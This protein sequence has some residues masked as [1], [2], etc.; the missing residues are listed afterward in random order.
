M[1]DGD[2]SDRRDPSVSVEQL[3]AYLQSKQWFED[4]RIRGVA[5]IWHRHQ[6]ND[7]EVVLPF[8][9]AKDFRQRVRDALMAI[10]SIEEREVFDVI[11]DVKRLF[12][13]VITVRVIHADTAD[14]TIPINDGV[15]L[16]SKAK[17]LLSA[18]AQ[19]I[20]AKRK[21]FSGS[22][23]KDTRDYLDTLLLGQTEI[24]SYVVNV[25]APNPTRS[26]ADQDAVS[27]TTADAVPL[28]QAIT[29]NLVTGLDALAKASTTY[30]QHGDLKA[31]DDAVLS[32]ASANLCDALL[33]FSG[34]KHN[35]AFEITVSA[36]AGPMFASE[37]RTFL[38]DGKRV[39]ALEKAS[40]YF[41]DDYVLPDRV[42]TG[43][44]TK[45]S[46]PR[47][48]TAGTITLHS[49]IG[50]VERKVR[51]ALTGDDYHLA[52]IAHDKAQLVRVKGDVHIKSKTAV[53]L[54]PQSFGVITMEDLF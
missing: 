28:S 11:S 33:G 43:H 45:L 39:E 7:G 24:G 49:T 50:D 44:I 40:G 53:L 30:E 27:P 6:D 21:H 3:Q 47:D 51:I 9:S 14:G 29:F 4:G 19:A 22:V 54:N 31:F 8:P 20:Y 12:S 2:R 15:L 13:N 18:S 25:I 17:D 5:T 23:P 36:V 46:R 16:I 10:A 52:V 42:L 32:G 48:E 34:E 37:P 35:R 26:V 38:F 41:K 1:T